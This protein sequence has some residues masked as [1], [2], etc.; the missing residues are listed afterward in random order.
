MGWGTAVGLG[1]SYLQNRSN[2]KKAA[3]QAQQGI[4]TIQNAIPKNID[5]GFGNGSFNFSGDGNGNFSSNFNPGLS[6]AHAP[7]VHAST[8][9]ATLIDPSLID[10]QDFT[11]L[12]SI[13][14]QFDGIKN[15]YN[16]LDGNVNQLEGVF[17]DAGALKSK[18]APGFSLLRDSRLGAINDAE[19]ARTSTLRDSLSRRRIAGSSFAEDTLSRTS[20]E[21]AKQRSDAEARTILEEIDATTNILNFQSEVVGRA[22]SIINA[23]LTGQLQATQGASANEQFKLNKQ[24]EANIFNAS[25]EQSADIFNA[26]QEQ[27][28]DI[29]N[30]NAQ[31][32]ASLANAQNALAA[33][34]INIQAEIAAMNAAFSLTQTAIAQTSALAGSL[35]NANAAVVETL[36]HEN[37]NQLEILGAG[38]GLLGG[39]SN[40]NTPTTSTGA[41]QDTEFGKALSALGG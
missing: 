29:F 8:I 4:N 22:A 9:E 27:S 10:Q 6:V 23:K 34:Q 3:N 26:S 25:Q 31:N 18:V 19:R 14:A 28:A 2:S 12:D 7:L 13:T 32:T 24:Q 41:G 36:T 17:N 11:V 33:A 30:A 38:I 37:D 39:Q 35:A 40:D 5:I 20:A 1:L 16:E 21:F 15:R